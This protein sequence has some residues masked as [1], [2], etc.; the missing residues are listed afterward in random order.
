MV[1]NLA[2]ISEIMKTSCRI[3]NSIFKQNMSKK[4]SR[5][6]R[7]RSICISMI[8]TSDNENFRRFLSSLIHPFF[9]LSVFFC[10]SL[11]SCINKYF[12]RQNSLMVSGDSYREVEVQILPKSELVIEKFGWYWWVVLLSPSNS[13][14]ANISNLIDT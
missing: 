14:L 4:K 6:T 12:K 13:S 1:K 2:V 3:I 10:Q 9:Y 7:K 5:K 8:F 11:P